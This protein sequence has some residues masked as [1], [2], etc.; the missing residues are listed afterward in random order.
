MGDCV[1]FKFLGTRYVVLSNQVDVERVLIGHAKKY[2][3]DR[4]LQ[5][6]KSIFGEGLL[7]SEGEKWRK[8]RKLIQ[9]SFGRDEL[10]VYGET[11][12]RLTEA[13]LTAL[14]PSPQWNASS[15]TAHL[16]LQIVTELLLGKTVTNDD[17]VRVERALDDCMGY[18]VRTIRPLEFVLARMPFPFVR[19]FNRACGV[20][21]EITGRLI[22]E[23][24][25][26]PSAGETL[27][28]HLIAALDEE[29]KGL[30]LDELQ[31]HVLTF[32]LAGHETTALALAS[33]LELLA[34]HPEAQ[35]RAR[36][37]RP[38]L[39]Q[40][41]H[42]ALR[43]K[44]PAWVLG[45][46]AL[47]ADAFTDATI[48][49]G[50]QVIVPIH[51]LHRHPLHYGSDAA[52]FRPDRW[53]AEFRQSLPR[54]AFM[55]FSFGARMCVGSHFAMM[56]LEIILSA[57]LRHFRVATDATH[58]TPLVGSITARPKRSIQLRLERI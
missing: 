39:E 38:Y 47:E 3:K 30:S 41:I 22:R 49:P 21:R 11:M 46:E 45:R 44:P 7:T 15:W 4:F 57:F 50:D 51:A 13:S 2:G 5:L 33:T 24:M 27:L 58:E 10:R 14:A 18:F 54:V 43:L 48:R 40:V 42:E 16:T 26:S 55:P 31:D 28:D 20:L 34:L 19:R 9:P 17:F 12:E 8:H 6:W 23:R 35:V 1:E 53:T 25:E 36:E 29:G 32:F 37:S 52:R 56:E